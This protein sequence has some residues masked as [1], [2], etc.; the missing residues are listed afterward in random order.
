M[1]EAVRRVNGTK[2]TFQS[3]RRMSA[4]GGKAD[5]G[6][7][8][9]LTQSGHYDQSLAPHDQSLAPRFCLFRL[10]RDFC[11]G[12]SHFSQHFAMRVNLGD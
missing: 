4:F 2:R 5:I 9:L 8:L 11:P 10:F 12:A 6:A 3:C 1:Q 7:T